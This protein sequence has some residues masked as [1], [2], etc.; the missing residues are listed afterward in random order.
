VAQAGV[1]A[2]IAKHP[3]ISPFFQGYKANPNNQAA[4]YDALTRM[5]AI[6]QYKLQLGSQA[7][8]NEDAV[9]ENQLMYP[10]LGE[11]AAKSPV[12]AQKL[13]ALVD[14]TIRPALEGPLNRINLMRDAQGNFPAPIL[15]TISNNLDGQ[16]KEL[17]KKVKTLPGYTQSGGMMNIPAAQSGL[18]ESQGERKPLDA[19]FGK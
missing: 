16:L 8:P 19:I 14:T 12:V 2:Y 10:S 11:I 1:N 18:S 9:K 17:E 6:E 15:R 13:N 4:L 7:T 5:G 3:G